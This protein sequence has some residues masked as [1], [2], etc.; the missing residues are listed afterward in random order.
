MRRLK[1]FFS[2]KKLKVS[3]GTRFIYCFIFFVIALQVLAIDPLRNCS[4]DV[5]LFVEVWAAVLVA[6]MGYLLISSLPKFRDAKGKFAFRFVDHAF[7]FGFLAMFVGSLAI[8]FQKKYDCKK[9]SPLLH[10]Y[11][12]TFI[13]VNG[14]LILAAFCKI[15]AQFLKRFR[16]LSY[17]DEVE[18][19]MSRPSLPYIP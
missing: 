17:E 15:L 8:F 2:R 12:K 5:I 11:M 13:I 9:K 1:E 19:N 4:L 14:A 3:E 16:N 7:G 10:F 18:M 6:W